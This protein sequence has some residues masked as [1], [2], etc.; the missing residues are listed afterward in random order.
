V[1]ESGFYVNCFAE[2]AVKPA[3]FVRPGGIVAFYEIDLTLPIVSRPNVRLWQQCSDWTTESFRRAGVHADLGSRLF[4]AFLQAGLPA[5]QMCADIVVGGGVTF[6]LYGVI[7]DSIRSL[8]PAME[9]FGIATAEEVQVDTLAD[10]LK[11]DTV[12][13]QAQVMSRP[14]IGAWTRTL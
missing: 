1:S 10:R 6:P 4:P 7:A 12:A 5:P 8:L 14:M 9:K 2:H 3:T 11:Q 13:V